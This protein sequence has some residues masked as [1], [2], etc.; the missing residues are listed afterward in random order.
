MIIGDKVSLVNETIYSRMNFMSRAR[1][2][3]E[4]RSGPNIRAIEQMFS[5]E[6]LYTTAEPGNPVALAWVELCYGIC[7]ILRGAGKPAKEHLKK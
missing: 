3:V 4:S 1:S 5:A 7:Y 2:R 6:R